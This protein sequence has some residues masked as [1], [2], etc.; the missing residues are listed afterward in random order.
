MQQ[1]ISSLFEITITA[2][3]ADA[4]VDFDAVVGQPASFRMTGDV[5]GP[6]PA[7]LWTG[8]CK[9]IQQTAVDE[10]GV[11]TYQITIVPTL[12]L[13]TQRRNHRMFQ[14]LSELDIVKELLA[15]WGIEPDLRI[16]GAYPKREYRIQYGESDFAFLARMLE[17]AGISFYFEQGEAETR[18]VLADAPQT[19]QV[20]SPAIAFRDAAAALTIGREYVTN[21][22]VAQR[23]RPGRVTLRDHDPRLPAAYKLLAGADAA[24]G[25][26]EGRLEQFH[27]TPGAFQFGT[28]QAEGTPHADDKG[29]TR[30]N[31][32]E[33]SAL[34]RKRLDAKRSSA[35]VCTFET[36][37]IDLA[38]G[39][40]MS[41]LDHP[42]S[43]LAE[44]QRL[45]VVEAS[46]V[47]TVNGE[48]S[49][50]CE[51]R[52]ADLAFR[53]PL[54]TPKPTISG[55]ESAT[56]VGPAGQEIHTDEL[57][58]VRCHFHWD[59]ESRMNEDSS[60]WIHTSQPWGGAGYGG[61]NL[62]RIGQEVLVDFL[63]GDPDRPIIT[64]RVYTSVQK[65]P[66]KLPDNKTQSGWKSNSSPTTGG[67]NEIMFEDAA[68]RELVRMQAE[69]DLHKLVKNDEQV[70]IGHD[71]TKLV[72]NDDAITVGNDRTKIIQNDENST[73]GND[74]TK[75][76]QCN[77]R[78]VVGQNRSRTVGVNENVSIGVS[79][80]VSVGA[81]QSVD[82][83]T[84]SQPQRG[85]G[86]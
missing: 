11:S 55:V 19:S 32:K 1:R 49:H 75:L 18:L 22:S 23:V 20:R 8:I 78:H 65:T 61:T 53:P 83:G 7:R 9:H 72:Q 60:C 36:S 86:I 2:L 4:D 42:R 25:G 35:K 37:A 58:R 34:A 67:Y 44:G 73:I 59:R 56:V 28:D 50:H 24:G 41:I 15:E 71:R 14:Q 77:E 82:I 62:P 76:V 29:A 3:C 17:E 79:H 80:S 47:G 48:W 57:G 84:G 54:S 68:G 5:N 13:C 12:W 39:V 27:Y 64:G 43:D 33:G 81:D 85:G 74:R 69:K 26:V 52:R 63:G 31:E 46:H 6:V 16:T 30:T 38:P 40:V 70:T 66:Y 51:V 10:A 45:L 21:V